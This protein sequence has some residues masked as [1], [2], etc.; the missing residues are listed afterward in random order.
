M[1]QNIIKFSGNN[2]NLF[3]R[4][5]LESADFKKTLIVP[6]THNAIVIKDGQMLQTLSSGKFQLSAFVDTK[7]EVDAILE[8]LFM[9]KTA[10]L[11]ML[12]GTPQMLL[13]YD[14]QLQE[15]YYCDFSGDF[16]VQIGD[17]RKSFLYLVGAS[18]DLTADALQERLQSNVVSVMETVIVDYIKENRVLFNQIAVCKKEMSQKVLT[19]LSHKLQSEY[20]IAVFSFNIANIIIDEQD[21]AKL[22]NAYKNMKKSQSFVCRGCGASLPEDAKFC[23]KCGMKVKIGNKCPKCFAKNADDALFCSKCGEKL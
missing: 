10:K 21:Y 5:K 14:E 9:S 4:V 18:E 12:W 8:V 17:P 23:N 3:S 22:N 6:E 16:E 1:E 19:A 13:M 2:D 20:G 11:K 15:N 7:E